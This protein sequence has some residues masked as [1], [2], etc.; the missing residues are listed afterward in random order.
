MAIAMAIAGAVGVFALVVLAGTYVKPHTHQYFAFGIQ[1]SEEGWTV[2]V[3]A[4][5]ACITGSFVFM[6]TCLTR[7]GLRALQRFRR[8]GRLGRGLCPICGYDL[9]ESAGRCPECGTSQIE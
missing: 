7:A 4:A 3:V 5:L 9:R 1:F 6:L 2:L 8:A